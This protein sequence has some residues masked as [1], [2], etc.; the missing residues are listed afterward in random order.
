MKRRT[1]MAA[2]KRQEIIVSCV[3]VASA[4]LRGIGATHAYIDWKSFGEPR[5]TIT[6]PEWTEEL[7]G[8]GASISGELLREFGFGY[9]GYSEK[10]EPSSEDVLVWE[11]K[12]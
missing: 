2:M 8:A 3:R 9:G 12:R 6:G 10:Y 5:V 1:N 11:A 7:S 4:A